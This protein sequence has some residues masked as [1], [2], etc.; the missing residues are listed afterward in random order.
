MNHSIWARPGTYSPTPRSQPT[1]LAANITHS[2]S[3]LPPS[4]TSSPL[5]NSCVTNK[6]D[7]HRFIANTIP[8]ACGHHCG[9]I[10]P[11]LTHPP[12]TSHI[13][14]V[15]GGPTT[16]FPSLVL[17]VHQSAAPHG[18]NFPAW[19]G[20]N[21]HQHL[22]GLFVTIFSLQHSSFL[23]YVPSLSF[24]LSYPLPSLRL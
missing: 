6:H 16:H 21:P 4:S 8:P 11:W 18:R 23:P 1:L 14:M 3:H 10:S 5:S 12:S 7:Q 9:L 17:V 20:S 15:S 13:S 24:S 2:H 19:I 22:S